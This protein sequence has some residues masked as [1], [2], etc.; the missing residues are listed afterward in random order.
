VAGKTVDEVVL[1]AVSLVPD[2]DATA[3]DA[4]LLAQVGAVGGKGEISDG[5]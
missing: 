3:A 5:A 2:D 1:A 4:E